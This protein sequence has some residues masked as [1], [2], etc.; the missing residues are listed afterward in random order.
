MMC[1]ARDLKLGV[2]TASQV[3]MGASV[4]DCIANTAAHL[5]RCVRGVDDDINIHFC[6]IV[7]D[8]GKGYGRTSL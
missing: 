8:D 2:I 3:L 6:D 1:F 7:S 5:K 4:K